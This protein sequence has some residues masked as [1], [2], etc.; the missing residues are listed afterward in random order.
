MPRIRD[1]SSK[2]NIIESSSSEEKPLTTCLGHRLQ[3]GPD[4]TLS[5]PYRGQYYDFS[6]CLFVLG[7]LFYG[8][9]VL[10]HTAKQLFKISI[11][12]QNR[13]FYFL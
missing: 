2:Q 8:T 6:Y 7:T 11:Q 12:P 5:V 13:L 3:Q 1:L 4:L 9:H 10:P